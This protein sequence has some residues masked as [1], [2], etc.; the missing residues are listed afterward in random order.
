MIKAIIFYRELHG[1]AGDFVVVRHIALIY[2]IC[3]LS[4]ENENNFLI[5]KY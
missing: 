4:L 5:F 1:A 2:N 3:V